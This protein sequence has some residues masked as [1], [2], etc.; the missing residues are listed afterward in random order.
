MNSKKP[1]LS[2][3]QRGPIVSVV[4]VKLYNRG[5][6][7]KGVMMTEVGLARPNPTSSFYVRVST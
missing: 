5:F 6:L 1:E 7:Y 3:S 2:G 4:D